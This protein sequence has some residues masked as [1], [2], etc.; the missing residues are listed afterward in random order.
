[1]FSLF[2][3]QLLSPFLVSPLKT[4][5]PLLPLPLLINPP[6]PVSWPWQS[7]LLGYRTFKGPRASPPIDDQLGHPLLHMQLQP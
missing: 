7:P 6:T 4:P 2:T 3:F 5:Y 1:M